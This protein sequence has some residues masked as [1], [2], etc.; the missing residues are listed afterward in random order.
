MMSL[1]VTAPPGLLMRSTT[2]L[3]CGSSAAASSFSRKRDIGL[4]PLPS[5]PLR[6]GVHDDAVDVDDG[7]LVAAEAS[8]R[9]A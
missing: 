4:S 6:P 7:D 2:A 5:R 9:V 3:T 8:V 1:A